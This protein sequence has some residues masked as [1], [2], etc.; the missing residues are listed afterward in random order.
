MFI[1]LNI[2]KDFVSLPDR[3]TFP[4]SYEPHPIAFAAAQD[5]QHYLLNEEVDLNH[6]FG[7][8]T[9]PEGLGKMFGVLVV[10]N[11]VGELGYI[12]AYSG[13]VGGSNRHDRFVPPVFD[14]LDEN[15]FYRRGE[16]EINDI[17]R[18]IVS[19]EN[20][21]KFLSVLSTYERDKAEAEVFLTDLKSRHKR[22][23]EHRKALRTK[24][25]QTLTAEDASKVIESLNTESAIHH[26][27]WK[28]A[29]RHWRNR[30]EE[31]R[32]GVEVHQ[33]VIDELKEER[34]RRSANLQKRLFDQY[35]FLNYLGEIKSLAEIFNTSDELFPPSGAGEC[36]APKLLQFAFKHKY[37]PIALAEFW[38]GKSPSSEIRKHGHVYPACHGKCGPIL[39]H[40]LKGL[41]LDENPMQLKPAA[42]DEIATLYEDEYL[43]IIHKPAGVLSVPGKDDVSSVY[44]CMRKRYPQATGPL[45]VHRLD[46]STSG[47]M[48]IALSM[49]VYQNLQKQFTDRKV[50]KRYVAILEGVLESD[51]GLIDLPLR[52]DLDDRPR[53][54][55][56]FEH[57][58][59]AKTQ[60]K[61]I[62][63]T[64]KETRVYF[65]PITGRTHQLRVHAAHP[66]GL[67]TPIKGDDLYGNRADR[68]YLQALALEFL[69]PVT[70]EVI[71]VKGEEEF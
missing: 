40:M 26:F 14:M 60:W 63:K 20:E 30:L 70:G 23:K 43:A 55:V 65:Y 36:A 38:W 67:N 59:P 22:A 52:V 21:E 49:E 45:I 46:M 4:F 53:Q 11:G 56:C 51:S 16:E 2:S 5:L 48:I 15:G 8:E 3:F 39:G 10:E 66:L 24:A 29:S 12:S 31:S 68:L 61:V 47:L 6:D 54:L 57:G 44:H 19:L 18:R 37:R 32:Q 41:P 9:S 34:K 13:K 42:E 7:H 71:R 35:V 1:K 17:N 33:K 64:N 28:D 25:E 58:K 27:E 50:K 62:S 69:H